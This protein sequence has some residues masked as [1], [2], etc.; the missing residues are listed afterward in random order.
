MRPANKLKQTSLV[1]QAVEQL[2]DEIIDGSLAP[3]TSLPEGQVSE[4]LGIAR[5]TVREVLLR[6]ENEGLVQRQGRGVALAVTRIDRAD[7]VEIYTARFH[8]ETAGARA[9]N[10]AT[11]QAREA[12]EHSVEALEAGI[13]AADR[14]SQ[15]KLDSACHTAAVA[16]TGSRKLVA[17]H[18]QLLVEARLATLAAGRPDHE[19]VVANHRQFVDLLKAGRIDDACDQL[20]QRMDVAMER[21]LRILPE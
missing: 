3:G 13:A 16:L 12:L 19:I 5:P 8:L 21:L 20:K 10:T 4:W 9:F 7:V 1:D 6:L 17:L 18:K 2:R 14:R 11:P 15:S